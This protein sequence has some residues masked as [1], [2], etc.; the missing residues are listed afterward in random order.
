VSNSIISTPHDHFIKSM[1]TDSKVSHEFFMEHLPDHIR[2]KV[3]LDTLALQ[4]D[5]FIG[6]DLSKQMADLLYGVK[7][8]GEDGYFYIILEHQSV[9]EKLMPFRMVK[10]IIAILYST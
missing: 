9:Q 10:Y 3:D 6:E 7:I 5:S 2:D 1:M 8:N 4:P